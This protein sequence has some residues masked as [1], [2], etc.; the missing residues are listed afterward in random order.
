MNDILEK[1]EHV[2]LL[3]DMYRHLLTDKQNQ[4]L[5]LYYEEDMSLGEIS[6]ELGISRNA[7]FDNIKRA[8]KTLEGYEAK[9][10]LLEKHLERIALIDKIEKEGKKEY[11]ELTDYLEMLRRI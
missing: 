7:V 2:I 9:L 8:V 3:M 6:E 11:Q 4:Y 10:Q 1:K 5:S